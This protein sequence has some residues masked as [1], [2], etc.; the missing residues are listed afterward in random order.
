MGS[1]TE[2]HNPLRRKD[3]IIDQ[4]AAGQQVLSE[5]NHQ[6]QLPG[7]GVLAMLGYPGICHFPG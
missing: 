4:L 6:S 3:A 5:V 2:F 7:G 1:S